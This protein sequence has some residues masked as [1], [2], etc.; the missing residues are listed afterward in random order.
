MS[1]VQRGGRSAGRE[2]GTA[3]LASTS[4]TRERTLPNENSRVPR[5]S[6]HLANEAKRWLQ[7]VAPSS[8]EKSSTPRCSAGPT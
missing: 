4:A 2:A 5:P 3:R 1:W 7:A 8:P 6:H